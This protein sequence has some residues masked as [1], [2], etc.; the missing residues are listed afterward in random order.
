MIGGISQT[1]WTMLICLIGL[2]G[3]D[4]AIGVAVSFVEQSLNSKIGLKGILQKCGILAIVVLAGVLDLLAETAVI[5]PAVTAFFI[6][7]E[8]LSIVENSARL[9]VPIP[10]SLKDALSTLQKRS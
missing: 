7:N 9:G 10:E 6:A 3:L 2:N 1:G 4:Y 5:Q 8:G